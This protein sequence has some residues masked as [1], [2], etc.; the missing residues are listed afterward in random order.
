MLKLKKSL[1]VLLAVLMVSTMAL[2]AAFTTSAKDFSDVSP[3]NAFAAQ[4]DMLSDIGVIKGTTDKEFSPD[5]KVSREQM[6]LLL[7]RLMTGKDNSGRV[8]TSPFTDLYEP[9]YNGAISWASANGFILGTTASTFEPLG[10]ITLQDAIAMITRAL[11]Q[12]NDKTN[13][14][15]P[16]SYIDIG[17]RLGLTEGLENIP[18]EQTLT[19]AETAALLHNAITA[20]Y[21]IMKTVS[22]STVPMVTTVLRYVY[23]YE[24]GTAYITATNNFAMPGTSSVIRT[25]YAEISVVNE[26]GEL[27]TAFVK[28]SDLGIDGD[29][30]ARLGESFKIFYNI[31]DRTGIASIIGAANGSDAKTVNSFTVGNSNSFVQIDGVKY[32]VVEQYSS[33]TAT[34]ANELLVFAYDEDG[35]LAQIENN[36]S[37]AAMNG[38]FSL[39]LIFDDGNGR[40]DRAV[41]TPLTKAELEITSAGEINIAGGNKESALVGGFVNAANAKDG[42]NVLYYYNSAA[43]RLVIEEKLEVVKNV[44]VTRLS[45]SSAVIG[46]KTYSL[47]VSGTE[48]TSEA[49]HAKLT[50]GESYDILLRGSNVIDVSDATVGENAYASTYLIATSSAT[51][52]VHKD[53]VCYF[54]SANIGGQSVNVYVTNSEVVEG[55][56]YRYEA[57]KDGILTLIGAENDKFAQ[58]GELKTVINSALSATIE[59]NGNVYYTLTNGGTVNKFI[60]DKDTVI[61]VKTASG[62]I[63]K[64]GA[65]A[66][67]LTVNDGAK[68]VAIMKDSAGSVETLKYLY[69]SDGALGSALDTASFVKILAKIAVEQVDGVTMNVYTVYNFATGKV[70]NL[71]SESA[72]L[73]TGTSYLLNESGHITT[74]EKSLES[75]E[76]TGHAGETITIGENTYTLSEGAFIAEVEVSESGEYSVKNLSVSE[77]FGKTVSF[78]AS[79]NVISRI[80]VIG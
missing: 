3:D 33:S 26:D 67:T 54:I 30:D 1:A 73:V 15:Y 31:N 78:V 44:K 37:L 19:R 74:S 27:D 7:Y 53:R 58:N 42:D 25:G 8:N 32:N 57:D 23:G 77:V 80:L 40:A 6:A 68:I 76:V 38:F 66:S 24:S 48:F 49:V 2:S 12:T 79:G 56:I 47:G 62:F 28:V 75:G 16:W 51:P 50:V 5:E 61:V 4:I 59:K 72:S 69:I 71:Y 9:S 39:K 22:G 34:N 35:T 21:I 65:Y 13:A 29:I 60:T 52:V 14:G 64:T 63:Y 41:I 46:G 43:K 45:A 70:E 17:N 36:A 18:Y 55:D 11:G 20:D 10:G